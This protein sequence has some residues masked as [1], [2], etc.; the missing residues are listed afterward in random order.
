[1]RHYTNQEVADEY[2][3]RKVNSRNIQ[4]ISRIRDRIA[5]HDVEIHDY[6]VSGGRIKDLK[7]I[8]EVTAGEIK[9]IF[10]G[11][12]F[13]FVDA[14]NP[15]V[16]TGNTSVVADLHNSCSNIVSSKRY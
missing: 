13:D 14:P 16:R 3:S 2:Y 8:G 10:Q 4:Q 15:L 6:F 11:D 5:N 12:A 9:E 1:M 7:G